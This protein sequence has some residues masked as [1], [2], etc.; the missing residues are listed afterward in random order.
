MKTVSIVSCARKPSYLAE[1]LRSFRASAIEIELVFQGSVVE[2][3]ALQLEYDCSIPR[4]YLTEKMFDDVQLNGQY[5]YAETLL[6]TKDGLILEDDVRVSKK[7]M[8]HLSAVEQLIPDEK[9]IIALYSIH[10]WKRTGE[11]ELCEQPVIN[12]RNTQ[13]M[14]YPLEAARA[15]GQ[16][17]LDFIGAEPYDHALRT[18]CEV[19]GFKIFATNYSLAQHIGKVTT[20]LGYHH[21]SG[22]FADDFMDDLSPKATAASS[23]LP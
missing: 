10:R 14:L 9:S 15:F 19:Y 17:I 23:S 21:Q 20:G 16:H 18:F 7:F 12:F 3:S 13:A 1:T 6:H 2:I 4:V 11:I 8:Q 22:N 5:N